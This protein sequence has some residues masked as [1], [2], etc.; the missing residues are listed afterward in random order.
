MPIFEYQGKTYD[1][2]DQYIDSFAEEF[3]DAKTMIDQDGNNYSVKSKYYK[4]FLNEFSAPRPE[5]QK[6]MATTY[7]VAPEPSEG[8]EEVNPVD[9]A[10]GSGRAKISAPKPSADMIEPMKT[11]SIRP[12]AIPMLEVEEK[13]N[14][15]K[16]AER[17]ANRVQV[18]QL[19]ARIKNEMDR[20]G[21]ELDAIAKQQPQMNIP[22]GTAGAIYSLDAGRMSDPEMRTLSAAKTSLENA[23]KI[24]NEADESQKRENNQGLFKGYFKAARR[25]FGDKLFDVNTWDMGL[26]DASENLALMKALDAAEEGT[27]TPS[28]EA[29]LEAKSVELATNAYFGSYIGRGYKAGAT[30]AESLPFMLEM[31]INPASA[32]GKGAA[33]RLAKWALNKYG[34]KGAE[35]A[36][37][38]VGR[39]L[40]DVAGAATMTATTGLARTTADAIDRI[41]RGEDASKAFAK[42]FAGTTIENYSE[43]LGAYFAPIL[44]KSGNVTA[45]LLDKIHLGGVN[46]FVNNVSSTDLALFLNQLEDKTQWSGSLGELGEEIAGGLLNSAIVGDQTLDEVFSKENLT[47]TFLSVSLMG[48]FLSAIKTG[49]YPVFKYS[50][51]K[52]MKDSRLDFEDQFKD[53]ENFTETIQALS[54]NNPEVANSMLSEMQKSGKYTKEQMEVALQYAM[55]VQRY[56][57]TIKADESRMTDPEQ[58]PEKKEREQSYDNGYTLTEPQEMNDAKLNLE[59]AET[60]MRQYFGGLEGDESIEAFVGEEPIDK[61]MD[62]REK[63]DKKGSQLI[64][65]WMNA[66]ATYDGMTQ[67]ISDDMDNMIAESN[68]II[69]KRVNK[70]DGAIHTVTL[71][72]DRRV[73][74][75]KGNIVLTDKGLVDK[76]KSSE[77]IIIRDQTGKSEF[78][79]PSAIL[80]VEPVQNAEEL[81]K[82]NAEVIRNK[83]ADDAE[84]KIDGILPFNI[85]DVYEV[86]DDDGV[87]HTATVVGLVDDNTV[88]IM[89]DNE[90]QSTTASK[91]IVQQMSDAYNKYR[92]AEYN[93]EKEAQKAENATQPSEEIKAVTEETPAN[94]VVPMQKNGQPDFNAMNA[95]MFVDEYVNR[96]GEDSAT[97][98]ARKNISVAREAIAK[99]DKK[100][101]DVVDP[102]QMEALSQ[103]KDAAQAQLDRY[104]DILGRLGA[105]DNETEAEEKSRLRKDAGNK[106]A[107]L[108]PDGLPNVESFILA[109]IATGN[110]I[111]WS[112]KEV[113]GAV[114]SRGLGAELGYTEAER[115]KRL[116]LI[117][118]DA[119]TP[120]EY[121]ESLRERLDA[122]GIRYDE[123]SLRDAVLSVYQ[124]VDSRKGAWDALEDISRRGQEPEM[125]TDWEDMQ[126]QM[127]YKKTQNEIA[128]ALPDMPD[129]ATIEEGTPISGEEVAEM[130]TQARA[131]EQADYDAMMDESGGEFRPKY[132]NL[133]KDEVDI[134]LD[135]MK[136]AAE[137]EPNA[138]ELTPENWT[139][140]FGDNGI[141][142]TP[143]GDVKMGEG[144]YLKLIQRKREKYFSLIKPT[145]NNPDVIL[146]EYDPKD[147]AERDTKLLFVKTFAKED[148]RRYVHFESVT[149]Q[150]ESKEISISSHEVN[151]SDLKK[152]MHN[153]NVVHLKDSF[154]DS[155]GRLIEPQNEGSDL[156]PTPNVSS[157]SKDTTSEPKSQEVDK[158]ILQ[159]EQKVNINPTEAQKEAGNYKKGH[160]VIDG[161]D[162]T[163]ETPKGVERSGVDEQGNKWSVKMNN[164]YGYIR[165]TEGVDGDHID[166]FLSDNLNNWNGDV[167]VVDQ[168]KPDG[169]FDE[170][171]V[172]YGF[173]SIE[174][175]QQAYLANYS[176]GWKGL[177]AITGTTKEEFQKWVTSSHR[178]TKPFAEYK[179]VKTTEGQSASAERRNLAEAPV[180]AETPTISQES[181]QVSDQDSAPYTIAPVQYTT[182]KGKVLDMH[183]VKFTGTLTKEQQ[184]AAKELAKADKG[185]YDREKG[186]FMMRSEESARQLVDTILNNN[187]AVS[188]AQPVSM[189]DIQALNN[190][191]VLF[192]EPLL[193]KEQPKDEE[194]HPIWQY[195][196]HID[197]D[198]YTTISR[199]D[200]SSGYP[201]G[202]ALFRY[203]TDNPEE[204]LDILRNP[205]NGMQEALEAVGVTLE[206]KIKTRELDRKIKE[207]REQKRAE[208]RTNGVNGY[209]IGDKV[210]YTPASGTRKA[211]NATIHD[212]EEFGENKPVLDVG[213]A[214]VMYEVVEW[215]DIAKVESS[216]T[217]L[218]DDEGAA[219]DKTLALSAIGKTFTRMGETE[220]GKPY[221]ETLT[222]TGHKGGYI[223]AEMNTIGYGG[224]VKMNVTEAAEA[225]RNGRWQAKIATESKNEG[226]FGLV[227]DERM[228]ELKER[229]R[230]KLGGQMNI[231]IDP[232]ILAIGLEIAV[233]HLDRGAKTFTDF[234]KVMI[235]DLGD[236]IRPYL[237]AFY[238]GARE[239]PEVIENG[240]AS[241]M[242]S[243]NE[244]QSFDVANFDK[245]DINAFA[246]AEMVA[247]EA[248][249]K[250]DVDNAKKRIKKT[251]NNSKIEKKTV[252]SQQ[253]SLFD[254][255]NNKDNGRD[256]NSSADNSGAELRPEELP[257]SKSMGSRA[258][259]QDSTRDSKGKRRNA[260]VSSS[261]SGDGSQ[262]DV[263][264]D[265]TNEEIENIVSSVTDIVDDKIIITGKVTDEIRSICRQYKSGGV[266]K[267]GRGILD[268]YYTD[269]KIVD[270]VNML[271]VPYFSNATPIRVLEPSIGI[272]NFIE[273]VDNISTSNITAFEINSTT[274]RIA[275][276]LY[277]N[278]EVNLRS[279]ETEFIDESGNKKPLPEKYNLVIG[280]PPY[281]SHRGLYKGLGEES[282]IA[283]YEDYFVKRSLDVLNEGGILAM[284]LPSSWIDRH[285][286]YGGYTIERAYRLPSGAFEA[287]QVGTD[288]VILKKDS[289][290]PTTDHTPYFEQHPERI[291]GEVKERK[292]RYGKIEEFVEGGIDAA[293]EAISRENAEILAEKLDIDT[294]NDNL[295]NIQS[296]IDETG[297]SEKAIAIV[298]SAKDHDGQSSVHSRDVKPIAKVVN[299]KSKYKVELNRNAET[300]QTA[301]QFMHDFNQAEVDAFAATDYDGTI[302][303][304]AKHL[305][306][307]SYID[308]KF[309]HD[310]YYA[311]GD[312]Y[313]KLSLLDLEKDYIIETYGAK[314]YE[315][316]R[317]L[318][319]KVMPKQ[320]SLDEIAI[321]PNTAF[322]KNL[323]IQVEGGKTS[324]KDL[325]IEF[326]RKLPYKAFGDSSSWEVIGYVEN[327][328]VYGSDKQRNQ[329]IRERRKRVANDMFVKFLNEELSEGAKRQV[330]VAFNREYN[331]TYRPDYSNVPMFSKINKYF[332]GRPLKLTSVQLAGIGR[333]TVKGV[334][335]LA[336][337]VGFG[338][339]LSGILAMHE[340]MTK[341]FTK[342]PLIVVP[343]DNILN[344]WVETMEEV[345]PNATVNMLGNLGSGYDLTG[346][347]VN[348]GEFTIVTYE[349]LKAMSF[350]DYTYERLAD[351]F[352]YITEDLNKHQSERDIQKSIEK[353][354]ELKGK[355]KRGTKPTYIFEDFGFDWLTVDEVHNANHIVSKVRLDKSVASD[356]RSQSQRSS[357]LGIKTW[358]AAQYIQEENDGRNVLLLSA[359]P[360]TNKPLEYYSILSLVA[361]KMLESKG[362]F[363]V[364]QFFATFMEADN[365]LEIGANGRPVQKTNVR[366]FRN[367]G[368]FQQLLSEFIDIKGEED[369]PELVRPERY[370]KEYKIAQND[371]TIEA[372]SAA[373]ELLSNN[374]TVLQ[375][376]GHARAAAF[377]P[378][379]TSL[380]GT[381]PKN[382]KEFVKNSPKIDA[383]IK[384]IE[385]NLKD[386]PDAGQIIYSEVGVEYFPMIRDYLVNESGLKPNEVRIITGATSNNERVSIQSAF[387][388]GEVKIVIGSPAIKEGLNLQGNTTDMYILSLPWNFTQL[389][390]IEGRGWRQG[391]RWENIRINYMLTNDSVDVFML[392]R[393][394][395]KQGL[396]NEAMKSGSES[397]DVSDIDTAELKSALITDPSVRAEIVTLQEKAKLQQAK[398]QV[399]ADLSFV[400]RKYETYTKLLQNLD[401]QK[402]IAAQYRGWA[403][404]G[405]E[406]W[407][408]RADQEEAKIQKIEND[409]EEEK[410]KLLKKGVNVDDIV[411][412][413]EQAQNE[414]ASIQ[415]KIDNLDDYREDLTKKYRQENEAKSKEQ[416]DT[417]STYIKER[418]SENNSGFYKIRPKE[419]AK[420]ESDENN[421]RFR[422]SD[423]N[424]KIVN[425]W[426]NNIIERYN[427][428]GDVVVA[429]SRESFEDA[430]RENGVDETDLHTYDKGAY[431]RDKNLYLINGDEVV[432]SV[433][434]E[435][436]LFHEIW[437]DITRKIISSQ[438]L[439][440]IA[441]NIYPK[442]LEA[443]SKAF[444]GKM[445]DNPLV[446]VDELISS[447]IEFYIAAEVDIDGSPT[448]VFEA[449]LNNHL[450]LREATELAKNAM[451]DE[452]KEYSDIWDKIFWE[453][454]RNLTYYKNAYYEQ[455]RTTRGEGVRNMDETSNAR[456]EK[457]SNSTNRTGI[458]QRVLP[459]GVRRGTRD[460]SGGRAEQRSRAI[461]SEATTLASSL[462]VKL[463]IIEDVTEI[464][465]SNKESQRKKRGAKAW[466]DVATDQVY[467]VVPNATNIADAQQSVLHEVVA[468]KGLRDVIGRE[469]F[470]KFLDKVFHNAAPEIRAQIVRLASQNG[471]NFRVATEEYLA[472][473]AE[474]GF[475]GR[476]NR[477][478]WQMVRDFFMDMLRDAKI[479]IGYNIND[480][481]MRYMLWRTYQ[482][483]KS[484][485][486]MAVAENV[487]MQQKLGVGNFRTRPAGTRQMTEEED[488]VF[489]PN[490]IKSATDNVG[491]F[492]SNNDDVRFRATS[493]NTTPSTGVAR[494]IYD[495][496]LRKHI[497][498]KNNVGRIENLDHHIKEAYHDGMTSVKALQDAILQE[499]GNK[500]H[501]YEDVYTAEN[502]LSSKNKTQ[503]EAWER[504][505]MRPLKEAILTLINKGA[506]YDEIVDYILA[507]HGLERNEVFSA[508]EA[509]EEW[510]GT[511]LRDFSG[512]TEL[513]EDETNFTALAENMVADFEKKYNTSDLWSSINNATKQTLKKAYDSGLMSEETYTKLS[514]MFKYY[515]PLR[516]WAENLAADQYEYMD[517]SSMKILPAVKKANGRKSRPEDPIATIGSMGESSILQGNRNLMKQRLLNLA[518]N[519]PTSLLTVGRQWYVKQLDG[520]WVMDN[521]VIPEDATAEQV[522][523]IVKEHDAKMKS[524]GENATKKIQGLKLGLNATQAQKAQHVVQVKRNGMVYDIYVN[525]NPTAAQAINGF[526]AEQNTKNHWYKRW[527]RNTLNFMARAFTSRN[528]E[529]IFVNL[530]RDLIWAGTAVAIKENSDYA[531]KYTANIAAVMLHASIPQLLWKWRNGTLDES[532]PMERYFKEFLL[533]GGETG[534][535]QLNTVEDYKRNIKRFMKRAQ[536]PQSGINLIKRG[537]D[538]VWDGVEFLNRSAEDTTRFT[539]YM[540]SRQMGRS[541]VDSVTDAKEITVN[542]NRKGRGTLGARELGHLYLF[543]NAAI[544]SMANFVSLAK[545]HPLKT[546]A[547][548]SSF[549]VSGIT[550]PLATL[551]LQSLWGDDDEDNYWDL[552]EWVRRNNIVLWVGGNTYLTVSLPHEM[553]PFYG[554]GELFLS[555]LTGHETW[556]NALKKA[557][558]SFA[559]LLPI[560]FTGNGGNPLINFTPS[561]AQPIAQ[562][563]ANEDYF[564]KPIYR[565]NDY[566]E[567]DPEW[568][569]A[570]KGTNETLV[571][572]TEFVNKI[573]GGNA[574][575]SGT[576][577]LNPAV[578][579]HLAEGYL[580]GLGKTINKTAK[581]FAMLWNEDYRSTRNIPVVGG[582][583][584][585]TD[586]RKHDNS[587]SKLMEEYK[588]VD[589]LYTGYKKKARMG[590]EEYATLLDELMKSPEFRRYQKIKGYKNAIDKYNQLLKREDITDATE[591]EIKATIAKYKVEL[592]EQMDELD[593]ETEPKSNK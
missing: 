516:G 130:E 221:E 210:I 127:A 435:Q 446:V 575:K 579:E 355:M 409:I 490:Q 201:I 111:R 362:F 163:I 422:L 193:P 558:T 134:V 122:A 384:M 475:D 141:I 240:L 369:N 456:A 481:D 379:A 506:S 410:Q 290:V 106:I 251:I 375:G 53:D 207:E 416:G 114:T 181:E 482:M 496:K 22:R 14:A 191:D 501:G 180:K 250:K 214:P 569:K 126:A 479:A 306:Y 108:F 493:S 190:G 48:G 237:K 5:I 88:Q 321:S 63:G 76:A 91:D 543:F 282:K 570:Y 450:S 77:S 92:L 30:T 315:K 208:L 194:Y 44:T 86:M 403:Q 528:P 463:N 428:Q 266:A 517:D 339:T 275:K 170:H 297:G 257:E 538:S 374:E 434:A 133:S 447:A 238:N 100:I 2:A 498:G 230:K 547:A 308:G 343:N 386:R 461:I 121:A 508:K 215:S 153:N 227:S 236:V 488:V 509:G 52:N 150:K 320:K 145:L 439:K 8:A 160:I 310:F 4:D 195:S 177:G 593:A 264:K 420:K 497:N 356:F 200:V 309:V 571:D 102:N 348:D 449:Y 128:P 429:P 491:T 453:T 565:K 277:P 70:D 293:I 79:S 178:K 396:Y 328:Q 203:S 370:N 18:A 395:L 300:V 311:E 507:K 80:S 327:E 592:L 352:S 542:F 455:E 577:D 432:D 292:G 383:T 398:T 358:L 287:T 27:L 586:G 75:I 241:D 591:E 585:S 103:Q 552:P 469:N 158:K 425:S 45:N 378:Y 78:S 184:R 523:Q 324:L 261:Q 105:T 525:G 9:L 527:Y 357:D 390:Q 13:S 325:F 97:K 473:L 414:I 146:E 283:R 149:V 166:V 138:I 116:P 423:T 317:D 341:G 532:I 312:I 313:S 140:E 502:H 186:G 436:I 318:L 560:D 206:N 276:V 256:E 351:K 32:T 162:I 474:E 129:L 305:K 578:L 454:G 113:N 331:S 298:E 56:N 500:L 226:Q 485:G 248:E 359:T 380:I 360:F 415:A 371:L 381:R 524:Y 67:R 107:Q 392:Q 550:F 270:A 85:N 55:D 189:T 431:F 139:S 213:L 6:A 342:K 182:K 433:M 94:R 483:Q 462:G 175:A 399:E 480:N 117:G 269:G 268:E 401:S 154:F 487:A 567:M 40:G 223:T 253:T 222:F 495:H 471:W 96:Y 151:E 174:E 263:N 61:V 460:T 430:L 179:S 459:E 272:G 62:Y 249:V 347:K 125:D 307:A 561:A 504:D 363:N 478:F 98:L 267:K 294:T 202:D 557:T 109:D 69:Y 43:M 559:E 335:V 546:T 388:E 99:I 211:I 10:K 289:S 533:N 20:R 167:Y 288:I 120:E 259:V 187:D 260:G 413:T 262:Y 33:N 515:V 93:A 361:N 337:E 316:Q 90:A 539:V 518:L 421:I 492:D 286:K 161:F 34:K 197:A 442:R 345:L 39:A 243:Y 400:L 470:N 212:F 368:M 296:A 334:G 553:R 457:E 37:K 338:K 330:V 440:T 169:S 147:G 499:T 229:L 326:C 427:V 536:N 551:V 104:I 204:M 123:S 84:K 514:G 101:D 196:I 65:D 164:T 239:L 554:I 244:V 11:D 494:Q 110:R 15:V 301:S 295:N 513:T 393:L 36:A 314:Q 484:K 173:N 349:G 394:Q 23:Q 216:K 530:S 83:V 346:F 580:G 572:A 234:A 112:D 72:D 476:E 155:E 71:K 377:S 183:L 458:V 566:N 254:N 344:Q 42:A 35:T 397:L 25:G 118:K 274:A 209:K 541:I 132:M 168:V 354:K 441:R 16:D 466:Y 60:K 526:P 144:Q 522:E 376:I 304:P 218:L 24:I 68:R 382:H 445:Y 519:N 407:I 137:I 408:Q 59:D 544:Q 520:T 511:N 373:Q 192:T 247:K 1:V 246:T 548:V 574:V 31:M 64:L 21:A 38:V 332:K 336:H 391:N 51:L 302:H 549:L 465:D 448:S 285:N 242:T 143:I 12:S 405:K 576:I 119:M 255:L 41:N 95:E 273:A 365:E 258:S 58:S 556:E 412:Q 284:V 279:F 531:K 452:A 472:S 252:S 322:V 220:S 89:W 281:G 171:K 81:V 545:N 512:L 185:W 329:L 271:I 50:A 217:A 503:T 199:D 535:T 353:K 584:T 350:T 303:N 17:E 540:T 333:M 364:D 232:E 468:H 590:S 505:Y 562:V 228:T 582:F 537:W 443:L 278:I 402:K 235:P 47:Q 188:D 82:A 74:V 583:L 573:T 555:A 385:Q 148:G 323:Y 418:K 564:G 529:F 157:E 417:V 366:R 521:P 131:E 28:Q 245:K 26:K 280:N 66:K 406:F 477:T 3:P 46:K 73:D 372:M 57:G 291:L 29:L 136:R 49:Y 464:V 172:M 404:E 54:S 510:D 142:P 152:K 225:L 588:E 589:H 489:N 165:G 568:T 205:L 563:L 159:E 299:N 367:N 156:V 387:N 115:R 135:A 581:T 176:I 19:S 231:G 340:A 319:N 467:F 124:S 233:G 438:Q 437:H 265:Y 224:S 198:G 444:W 424:L 219:D 534:F 87:K 389:R 411:S 426:Y 419:D 451:T 7:S 486:A 587:Y